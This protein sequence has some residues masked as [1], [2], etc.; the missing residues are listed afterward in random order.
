MNNKKIIKKFLTK[1]ILF[2]KNINKELNL[3]FKFFYSIM[4]RL[5]E[6]FN[7]KIINDS[8]ICKYFNNLKHIMKEFIKIG[9]PITFKKLKLKKFTDYKIMLMISKIKLDLI[10]ISKECGANCIKDILK[11]VLNI[12]LNVENNK[13][14]NL[15]IFYNNNYCPITFDLFEIKK[16]GLFDNNIKIPMILKSDLSDLKNNNLLI[17]LNLAK[18]YIPFKN[19]LLV[20]DGYFKKDSIN[21]AKYK[22]NQKLKNIKKLILKKYKNNDNLINKYLDQILIRDFLVLN[23]ETICNNFIKNK[24]IL[25]KLKNQSISKIIKNFLKLTKIEKRNILILLLLDNDNNL[26]NIAYVCFDIISQNNLSEEI[27]NSFHF[28]IQENL[29]Y[30]IKNNKNN[31]NL[32]IAEEKISY[33]KKICL[34]EID[35]YVKNKAFNKLKEIN[36]SKGETCA[37]AQQYLDG[38]LKIPFNKYKK[39]P[40]I[41]F[42]NNF[43]NDLKIKLNKYNKYNNNNNNKNKKINKLIKHFLNEK[44]TCKNINNFFKK[45]KLFNKIKKEE[46]IEILNSFKCKDLKNLLLKY[47]TNTKGKKVELVNKVLKYFDLLNLTNQKN[48]FLKSDIIEWDNYNLK[49]IKYL[50]NID[51]ILDNAIYGMKDAKLQIKRIICQWINGQNKGYIFGFEGPP[52]IGKTTLAKKGL[53]NCM[54]DDDNKSRPFSFIA[55]GGSCNGS[56]IEGHNYTY[57]GSTWGKIVDILMET[58]CMNP[59][60]Y[61]D[62][63]DKVSRTEHG[64]EIIGILTHLIDPSQNDSFNDKYFSGINLDLSKCLIIFSYNDASLIDKVLLDRIH[65]INIK[66]LNRYEKVIIA[67][68]FL[69]PEI[70]N[71][72]GFEKNDIIIKDNNLF[73]IIDNFTNESGVRK[74]KEHLYELLRDINL[75]FMTD[76]LK[77][78]FEIKKKIIKEIFINKIKLIKTKI[79]SESKIGLINGLFATKSGVGGITIVETYKYLSNTKLK[80]ELTGSQGD[81]MKESMKVSLTVA[82][83]LLP[84]KTKNKIKKNESFGIHIHCPSTATP[85]DGPSASVA[86]V[87]AIYS[88]LTNKKI[89]NKFAV[90]GEINLT[91]NITAIGGLQS[92]C[93]GAK[94]AG[95]EKVFCPQ[96]N[97][98]DVQKIINNPYKLVDKNFKIIL[99]NNIKELIKL[100]LVD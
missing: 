86:V 52:G 33:D 78:P 32:M 58:Q 95:I 65:R 69:I 25:E 1:R 7:K 45:Y 43:H 81:I 51:T 49:K 55:L 75:R 84:E 26:N 15:L 77:F 99:V 8:L 87:V 4:N 37:K 5:E 21:I 64:R 46:K 19:N 34:L 83:N 48:D 79:L 59:I 24:I 3:I 9:H 53:A 38:L 28:N 12:N 16:N 60:I 50:K 6:S 67:K 20:L 93:E 23:D 56:T 39:E 42:L 54:L 17:Q 88:L 72:I 13:F 2:L 94:L 71:S 31:S 36:N 10:N 18:I 47:E 73:Y 100:I 68:K 66:S 57:V 98:D 40:I 85:K 96:E 80:L 35:D 11:L 62:E 91:G 82:W 61:I 14:N 27:Y 41:L 89:Y 63:L 22:F 76:N 74:L 97:Y 92:K 30:F 29:K 90:T 70:L 44:G